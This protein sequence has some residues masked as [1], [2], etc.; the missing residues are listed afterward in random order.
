M[1]KDIPGND[2][3]IVEADNGNHQSETEQENN[4]EYVFFFL[5]IYL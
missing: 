3:N 4:S 1:E 2:P 5:L